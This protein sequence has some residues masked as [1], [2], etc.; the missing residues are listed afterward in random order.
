[1][2]IRRSVPISA[3]PSTTTRSAGMLGLA[4][5]APANGCLDPAAGTRSTLG[6]EGLCIRGG[7]PD[8]RFT[9]RALMSTPVGRAHRLAAE[10]SVS[11][12]PFGCSL[13]PPCLS[14]R[15]Q[16]PARGRLR[17]PARR[18]A[19]LGSDALSALSARRQHAAW[20]SLIEAMRLNMI[21]VRTLEHAPRLDLLLGCM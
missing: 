3:L 2:G 15:D 13:A 9:C 8:R 1:M 4:R 6:P 18:R 11:R 12:L 19:L 7:L 21:V 5:Q 14:V 10:A 17:R 16:G 20:A